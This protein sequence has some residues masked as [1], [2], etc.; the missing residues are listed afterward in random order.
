MRIMFRCSRACGVVA[1]LAGI[2]SVEA[3]AQ[4]P[5]PMPTTTTIDK[6]GVDL[7]NWS[8]SYEITS[9]KLGDVNLSIYYP[10]DRDNFYADLRIEDPSGLNFTRATATAGGKTW[11]FI[12]NGSVQDPGTQLVPDMYSLSTGG[13]V[14]FVYARDGTV[15]EYE[16]PSWYSPGNTSSPLTLC[17]SKITK[18][19]GEVLRYYI[20]YT[21]TPCR[22]QS[23][24]SNKGYQIKYN[25]TASFSIIRSKITLINNAYEYCAPAA[26]SC[27][28]SMPWPSITFSSTPR[29][30]TNHSGQVWTVSNGIIPPGQTSPAIS[31]TAENYISPNVVGNFAWRV[32]S[33]TRD[34]GTWLYS[35]PSSDPLLGGSSDQLL[36][37]QDPNGAVTRYRRVAGATGG[38]A[39]L[40]EFANPSLL[41]SAAD[42]FGN[43]TSYAY[44]GSFQLETINL[45]EGRG[46]LATYDYQGNLLTYTQRPKTGSGAANLTTSFTYGAFNDLPLSLTD[47]KGS[48]TD[49]T[50]DPVHRGVLTETKPAPSP[51][52]ARPVT[53]Y[54]Y[55]QR[56]AWVKNSGGGYVQASD[57]IWVLDSEKTCRTSATISG[58]CAAGPSDEVTVTYDYGPNSGPNNLWLRGRIETADGVSRRTCY[59][60]DAAGNRISETQPNANL[61]ACP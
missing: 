7:I 18:P 52:A 41:T 35:Y 54:A 34:G 45:P 16:Y 19:D 13:Y 1:L 29:T 26:D 36:R 40:G 28:L 33:V 53:R 39:S 27:T 42:P 38:D 49:Y 23:I 25:Y 47:P 10:S 44:N 46:H 55:S 9:V 8:Y 12:T 15:I 50:Y 2:A 48:I 56:Y 24:V 31:W 30:Y 59:G 43:V 32:T 17:A 11:V 20:S 37:V 14:A 51:G 21:A 6:N 5:R 4:A 58:G 3:L 22:I 61:T 57:P 60:Y